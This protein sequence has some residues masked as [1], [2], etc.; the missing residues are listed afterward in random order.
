MHIAFSSILRNLAVVKNKSI[1]ALLI[2]ISS[3][4]SNAQEFF[5]RGKGD[6]TCGE[7]IAIRRGAD[8]LE[9]LSILNYMLG[10]INGV[11]IQRMWSKLGGIKNV[12][13]YTVGLMAETH[14]LK[15]PTHT[16]IITTAAI[17]RELMN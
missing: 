10:F 12:N 8:K 13:G 16:M 9:E 14:C 17:T 5:V 7:Y 6:M 2:L 1:I 15:N 4:N 11:E 3:L